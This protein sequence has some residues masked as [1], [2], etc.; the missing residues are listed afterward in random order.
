MTDYLKPLRPEA[1]T[2]DGLEAAIARTRTA[3]TEARDRADALDADRRAALLTADDDTLLKLEADAA[4]ARLAADRM[5]ALIAE[6][7]DQLKAAR[8]RAAADA[9]HEA[10]VAANEMAERF[11]T[12]WRQKYRTAA[13]TIAALLR[14]EAEQHSA[15]HHAVAMMRNAEA[16]GAT[17]REDT[18]PVLWPGATL[19]GLWTK[20][21][22]DAVQ[23]PGVLGSLY[24][25]EAFWFPKSAPVRSWPHVDRAAAGEAGDQ[26]PAR[27]EV[28]QAH[29]AGVQHLPPREMNMAPPLSQDLED[30]QPDSVAPFRGRVT[31]GAGSRGA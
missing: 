21:M 30:G 31:L 20:K 13:E 1:L 12:E 8:L 27:A 2:V 24:P 28:R 7:T 16:V 9:V 10:V 19:F 29:P 26:K 3:I 5:E 25:Q 11:Q 17:P 4:R 23:L 22:G 15:A 14:L 6:M 18:P